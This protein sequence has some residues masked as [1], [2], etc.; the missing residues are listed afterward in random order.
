[1]HIIVAGIQILQ[2][3]SYM[4]IDWP[5]YKGARDLQCLSACDLKASEWVAICSWTCRAAGSVLQIL[6]GMVV[7]SWHWYRRS[8]GDGSLASI[9]AAQSAR[10]AS[11]RLA[12]LSSAHW[13]AWFTAFMHASVN[14]FNCGKWGLK[15]SW[16]I[17]Q[18][19]QKSASWAF[20][21][22][23]P[24]SEQRAS[25]IPCSGNISLSSKMTLAEVLWPDGRHHTRIIFE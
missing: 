10:R 5:A 23:R 14:P 18:E 20:A 19:V 8:V 12:L 3:V 17:P 21:Y 2:R 1:M 16:V 15:V 13:S 6:A 25:G 22:C 9:G 7:L 11:C 4:A 24:L